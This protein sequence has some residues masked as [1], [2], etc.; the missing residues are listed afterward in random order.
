[1]ICQHCGEEFEGKAGPGRRPKFCREKCRRTADALRQA[2]RRGG[3]YTPLGTGTCERCG[4]S[5]ERKSGMAKYC[6]E[7]KAIALLD[8]QHE[9]Y[10]RVK[11][12]RRANVQARLCERCGQTFIPNKRRMFCSAKCQSAWAY[13]HPEARGFPVY[14]CRQCGK[15]F[16]PK[17][18][19]RLSYCSRECSFAYRKEHG[20]PD[21]RTANWSKKSVK[22]TKYCAVCGNELGA[23]QTKTCCDECRRQYAGIKAREKSAKRHVLKR[24]KCRKCGREFVPEYGNKRRYF[25]SDKC[26]HRYSKAKQKAV[27]RARMSGARSESIHPNEIL[28]R[29]GYRCY[30]CGCDT[31]KKLRNTWQDSAPQVDHIIPVSRGGG[32]TWDNLACICRKCN[33]EKGDKT[34]EEL[35]WQ[36]TLQIQLRLS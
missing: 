15:E 4:N 3:E 10:E 11:V 27:R 19:D 17:A 8:K 34:L 5:Y 16:T 24:R 30:V 26:L 36:T 9:R 33:I 32:W 18:A 7:C 31:P 29:D 23:H 28:K 20:F 21:R 25:C 6:D 13:D 12:E 1:M 2:Q 22:R 35:G 14:T